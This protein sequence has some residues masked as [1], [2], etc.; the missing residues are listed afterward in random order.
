MQQVAAPQQR[1][2]GVV[3]R[4]GRE[5]E[6]ADQRRRRTATAKPIIAHVPGPRG[7]QPRQ[8]DRARS[9]P[10]ERRAFHRALAVAGRHWRRP[11]AWRQNPVSRFGILAEAKSRQSS[12]M[13]LIIQIPCFNEADQLPQTLADLPREVDGFDVVE[14][15]V[16]RRRLD[17]RHGRGRARPRRRSSRAPDQQQGPGRRLSGGHRHGPEARRGR[18]RQHRRRQPVLRRR[19]SRGSCAR[20]STDAPTWWSATAR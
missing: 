4:I 10:G 12:P 2:E 16:D 14:W 7:T 6:V 1:V 11:R 8:P 18:D 17:R 3:G 5:R 20:S 9:V 15:L 13:K 19:T